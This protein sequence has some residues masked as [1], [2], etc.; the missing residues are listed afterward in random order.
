MSIAPDQGAAEARQPRPSIPVRSQ[1]VADLRALM[2]PADPSVR[3]FARGIRATARRHFD[4]HVVPRVAEHWP[5][6]FGERFYEKLQIGACD[7]YAS[8]PYTALF[9]APRR[10]LLVRAV[11]DI[12]NVLPLPPAMLAQLGRGAMSALGRFA[13][14]AQ[15]RRIILIA[16]FIVVVDH[17]FDHCMKDPPVERERKLLRVLRGEERP[18]TPE[19]AL[20]ASLATAMAEGLDRRERATFDA[21]MD[22]VYE[23]IHAEV[24]AM[25]GEPDPTGLGHRMAGIEGTIDGLL[26]PVVHYGG[27]GARKWMYDVS[28]FVQIADDW[29]DYDLDLASD[30]TT[31][32]L[33]GDW[34]FRDVEDSWRR[35]VSGLER[36]VADAGLTSPRYVSFVRNAYVLMMSDVIE[37]MAQRPDE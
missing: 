31:P 25:L 18:T 19:L 8:A 24:L 13:Y 37:A 6:L 23:W 34:T 30:R 15:H 12:G 33:T 1:R 32:V 20:T 4:L 9:C 29:L 35:S 22:R 26:F 17:V 27:E 5:A 10:P 21:A 3:P 28:L 16:S 7:L 2:G 14:A 11:T 36:L